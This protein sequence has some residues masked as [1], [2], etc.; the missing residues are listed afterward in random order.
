M[1]GAGETRF[2]FP[3]EVARGNT[4]DSDLGGGRAATVRCGG[5]PESERS[6]TRPSSGTR[7]RWRNERERYRKSQE[8]IAPIAD[9]CRTFDPGNFRA[10]DVREHQAKEE[11][12]QRF[13]SDKSFAKNAF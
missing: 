3:G 7:M 5:V 9:G 4:A 13:G 11:F 2:P 6:T 1:R 12:E 8:A 10:R